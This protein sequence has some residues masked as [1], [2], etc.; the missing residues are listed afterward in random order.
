MKPL[1]VH[2]TRGRMTNSD[3]RRPAHLHQHWQPQRKAE[4]LPPMTHALR[5][6][7]RAVSRLNLWIVALLV[8]GL[9]QYQQVALHTSLADQISAQP[10]TA[11]ALAP[12]VAVA[13]PAA[14][15]TRLRLIPLLDAIVAAPLP[16]QPGLQRLRPVFPQTLTAAQVSHGWQARAPPAL[17]APAQS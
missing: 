9:L 8:V 10:T 1:T 5:V 6:F 15:E 4:K 17:A 16:H 12:K 2:H 11:L 7:D 3:S 14:P 13:K